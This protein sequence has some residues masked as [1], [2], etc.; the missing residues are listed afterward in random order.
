MRHLIIACL[1][2]TFTLAAYG[3][4]RTLNKFIR[5]QK[6]TE[7][8]VKISAPGWIIKMGAAIGKQAAK[9]EE[10]QDPLVY[11]ALKIA[12][13]IKKVKLLVLE[14]ANVPAEDVEK[15]VRRVKKR[16]NY[17]DLLTINADGTKVHFMSRGKGDKLK[18]ML[19]LVS[20]GEDGFVLVSLKSK[21]RLSEI[22][23]LINMAIKEG[24]E[25]EKKE[26]K[27]LPRA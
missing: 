10:E 12:K 11:E 15:L 27:E 7:N 14:D 26:E 16:H 13:G 3:Q 17:E 1:L 23:D 25:D 5:Q 24:L 9:N 2:C 4:N 19:F 8:S 22:G 20:D 6:K 21:L 18:N